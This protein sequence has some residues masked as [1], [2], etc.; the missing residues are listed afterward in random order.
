MFLRDLTIQNLRSIRNLQLSFQ[1]FA[2]K[3]RKWTLILGENGCG[4]STILRA[5]AL[6]CAGSDALPHLLGHDVDSWIHYGEAEAN[7]SAT[8]VTA[9]GQDRHIKLCLKRGCS[10]KELFSLNHET[11]EQLDSA[12]EHAAR[13]YLTMGYG[14]SRRLNSDPDAPFNSRSIRIPLRARSVITLFSPEAVLDPL[15]SWVIDMDYRGENEGRKIIERIVSD[16][17]PNVEFKEIDKATKQ[18]IFKTPDGLTPLNRLSDGYQNVAAWCGDLLRSITETFKNYH[19]PLKARGLLLIDEID[20]HLH[21]VWQRRLRAF[22]DSTFP[23]LQFIA[24]THSPLTV[25]QAGEGELYVMQRTSPEASPT[26]EAFTGIPNTMMIHQLLMSPIFNLESMDSLK[27]Q[28]QRE[29]F[30]QLQDTSNRSPHQSLTMN[31]LKSSLDELPDFAEGLN[32]YAA[33][34]TKVLRDIEQAISASSNGAAGNPTGQSASSRVKS[35]R[36]KKRATAS[37]A[38]IETAPLRK[39]TAVKKNPAAK[40]V[41]KKTARKAR[42]GS[43]K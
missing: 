43:A 15:E 10:V 40:I 24:T 32:R 25:Q 39:K 34:Q 33:Q 5:V 35:A 13:S 42:K 37:S 7:I 29:Q 11:L 16:L 18:L 17:M 3:N 22:L 30:R 38:P 28:E 6:L 20:L 9:D 41:K 19:D 27:V 14:A 31:E 4:K 1:A 36:P 8:L 21:P 23:N 26:L 2:E 12:L